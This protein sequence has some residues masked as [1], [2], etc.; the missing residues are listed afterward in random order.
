MSVTLASDL[1]VE[2]SGHQMRL[3]GEGSSLV[4]EFDSLSAIRVMRRSL[5]S[6]GTRLPEPLRLPG[7]DAVEVE[8]RV[9]GRAVAEVLAH[10]HALNV[11]VLWLGLFAAILHLPVRG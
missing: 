9:R 7:L 5:P 4:A 2:H 3:R 8:V 10:D 6:P 11:R 1:L